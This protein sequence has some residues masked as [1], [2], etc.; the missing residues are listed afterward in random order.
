MTT[1]KFIRQ[2]IFTVKNVKTN[3]EK[4]KK[5]TYCHS[6]THPQFSAIPRRRVYE[7]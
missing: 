7:R 4:K 6:N 2:I 3:V 5:N 1:A